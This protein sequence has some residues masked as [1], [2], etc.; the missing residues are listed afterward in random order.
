MAGRVMAY[1]GNRRGGKPKR[2]VVELSFAIAVQLDDP[3]RPLSVQ[4]QSDQSHCC[5]AGMTCFT[6]IF[7]TPS[8]P[9]RTFLFMS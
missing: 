4:Y 3:A 9:Q 6:A 5:V 8:P 2:Q 7:A 1:W